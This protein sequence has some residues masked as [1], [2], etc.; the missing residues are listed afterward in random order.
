[1]SR[2]SRGPLNRPALGLLI[3]AAIIL[4]IA[5][6]RYSGLIPWGAR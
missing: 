2:D 5:L 6:L 4:L 3:V 1:M